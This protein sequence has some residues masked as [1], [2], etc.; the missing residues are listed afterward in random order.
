MTTTTTKTIRLWRILIIWN[1][2]LH[3]LLLS[4]SL[5]YHAH[6]Y[7]IV[8]DEESLK[9]NYSFVVFL[10]LNFCV[11]FWWMN[12][13]LLYFFSFFFCDTVRDS[14]MRATGLLGPRRDRHRS[15]RCLMKL[16]ALLAYAASF[17]VLIRWGIQYCAVP[18]RR[19]Y[20][21]PS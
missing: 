19:F 14:W 17:P 15:Q 7:V 1:C 12:V 18:G 9:K 3:P 4:H 8:K 6:R 10:I 5:W 11:S 21:A 20:S 16:A 13:I 2:I